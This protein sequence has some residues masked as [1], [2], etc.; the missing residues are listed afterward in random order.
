MANSTSLAKTQISKLKAALSVDSVKEQFN[1]ALKENA[2]VFVASII[3]LYSSDS[4]L[5]QCN[6]GRVI[7]EALKAATLH[8][9]IN[10]SLGFAYIVP[11]KIKGQYVPQM[12]IG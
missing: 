3:D 11:Y 10:K 2:G 6:P 8:L 1:N 12:Q 9:P 5:M 7:A 4:T